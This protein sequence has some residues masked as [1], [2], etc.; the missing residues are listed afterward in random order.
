M[1]CI[2]FLT[3]KTAPSPLAPSATAQTSSATAATRHSFL[4]PDELAGLPVLRAFLKAR[5]PPD[6]G[7]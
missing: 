1:P 3:S 2:S 4:P 5:H 6:G 7:I